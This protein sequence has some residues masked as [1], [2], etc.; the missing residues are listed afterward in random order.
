LK[1]SPLV[2]TFTGNIVPG[3]SNIENKIFYFIQNLFILLQRKKTT[4]RAGK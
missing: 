2:I 4:G 3:G 1:F